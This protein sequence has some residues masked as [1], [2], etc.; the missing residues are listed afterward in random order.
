MI[1]VSALGNISAALSC[2]AFGARDTS[3]A[4]AFNTKVT[5]GHHRL[6][7]ILGTDIGHFD[8]TDMSGVVA[9]AWELVEDGL[10]TEEDFREFT[11][12]NPVGLWSANNPDF[13][14]GTVVERAAAALA[15]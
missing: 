4:W 1:D 8:V 2:N 3:I 12:A 13:F 6:H 15:H 5:P 10:I 7:A 11:F 9:E 14:K